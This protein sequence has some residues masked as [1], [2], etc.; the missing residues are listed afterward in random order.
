MI[1]FLN[2]YQKEIN[3]MENLVFGYDIITCNG[4]MPNCF[5]T[6]FFETIRV[7]AD[8]KFK[9]SGKYWM[10]KHN[11]SWPLYNSGYFENIGLTKKSISD[12]CNDRVIRQLT[13]KWFY[14]I[15]P[16]GDLYSLFGKKDFIDGPLYENISQ[17]ALDE[18]INYNGNL[19]IHYSIDGGLGVERKHFDK[20]RKWLISK[21]VPDD[22]VYLIFSDF[23]IGNSLNKMGTNYKYMCH[24]Q[25]LLNKADEYYNIIKDPDYSY[26]GNDSYE[27]Q[28][29]KIDGLVKSSVHNLDELQ[30][31][32]Q[33]CANRDT[34]QDFLFFMRH[35]KWERL[36]IIDAL[37]KLGLDNSKVSWNKKLQCGITKK[38]FLNFIDNK[39][40]YKLLT[41]TNSILDVEDIN[42]IAGYGFESGYLYQ[43]TY[44][45]II[46]ESIFWQPIDKGFIDK[47]TSWNK[48][49]SDNKGLT[50]KQVSEKY[51]KYKSDLLK[52][53]EFRCGYL[54][55]K[56]WKPIAHCHPFIL[57]GP[58][59]S[60]KYIKSIGFKTFS[61]Y[62][63]ESYDNELDDEKRLKMIIECINNFAN[64][65]KS[66]KDDF[67]K[68]TFSIIE[69]NQKMLLSKANKVVEL[70]KL[71]NF[72]NKK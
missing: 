23:E 18:I 34:K 68:D 9:D 8:W 39:K 58:P 70:T 45:S 50:R 16:F 57:V 22:K 11:F 61:P 44:L 19:L 51:K 24:S 52:D 38:D 55:E 15:E 31:Y 26:W 60:L 35:W 54:S 4:E 46:G 65:S 33:D 12:I 30:E 36:F 2:F 25:A 71:Y 21:N 43:Y 14:P 37:F 69:H 29:G 48:Y 63:D 72:L 47:K 49:R 5:P 42:L 27:P 67:L 64:K 20:L 59:K 3:K 28:V 10:D 40:L 6:K 13:Y 32:I 41:T 62:L 7:G 17:K 56:I 1:I 66:E 53:K